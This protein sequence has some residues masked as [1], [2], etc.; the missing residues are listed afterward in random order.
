MKLIKLIL[1][2]SFI[3]TEFSQAGIGIGMYGKRHT[4]HTLDGTQRGKIYLKASR[5]DLDGT[6]EFRHYA[7]IVA[8]FLQSN[9][10]RR[11]KNE[12]DAKYI[13]LLNYGLS[14][15]GNYSTI[16]KLDVSNDIGHSINTEVIEYAL[17]PKKT[18]IKN[19]GYTRVF[20]L[21]IFD[22]KE[23][24]DTS[25]IYQGKIVSKGQCGEMQEVAPHLIK[26][27]FKKWPGKN[28]SKRILSMKSGIC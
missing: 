1:I 24:K 5:E 17:Y 4:L 12:S 14:T 19:Q 9:G 28:G 23:N 6:L 2:F 15:E 13:G 7:G 22:L 16:Y 10:F 8:E 27:M 20:E 18:F 26:M 3:A 11:T 25:H 21:N